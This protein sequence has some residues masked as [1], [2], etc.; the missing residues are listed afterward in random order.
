M[1]AMRQSR[2]SVNNRFGLLGQ[3]RSIDHTNTKPERCAM[4]KYVLKVSLQGFKVSI[5]RKREN[6]NECLV[7]LR[8]DKVMAFFSKAHVGNTSLPLV[9]YSLTSLHYN[10]LVITVLSAVTGG[11]LST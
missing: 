5:Q 6:T 10:L 1:F 11:K 7:S 2:A 4:D 3:R 9:E 8:S